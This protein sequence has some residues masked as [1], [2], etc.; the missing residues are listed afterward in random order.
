MSASPFRFRTE[1]GAGHY[2]V[3][4]RASGDRLGSVSK[5]SRYYNIAPRPLTVH[6]WRATTA[7]HRDLGREVALRDGGTRFEPSHYSTRIEAA[8]ALLRNRN[9]S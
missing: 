5:H 4:D 3:E 1:T 2:T 8:E 7:D 6:Y 9:E